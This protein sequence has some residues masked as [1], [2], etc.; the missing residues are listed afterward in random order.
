[1]AFKLA[2]VL[3]LV[4]AITISPVHPW[5]SCGEVEFCPRIRYAQAQDNFN[6]DL[7]NLQVNDNSIEAQLVNTNSQKRFSFTLTAL[8]DETYRV[9]I[10]D[11]DNKRHKVEDA[12]DGEPQ[13]VSISTQQTSNGITVSAGNSKA[14]VESSPFRIKFYRGNDVIAIINN[15]GRFAFEEREPEVAIGLDVYFPGAKKAYGLPAHSD[16]LALRNT[17]QNSYDPYR[18]YNIDHAGFDAFITQAIYGAIPVLYAHSASQSTGFFWLNSAQT[19]VDID[20]QDSGLQTF[21]FSES[22][23]MD[24]F[25]LT[26]PSLKDAVHQYAT[27]TGKLVANTFSNTRKQIFI[28]IVQI[29]WPIL[30]IC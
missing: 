15:Q 19:F 25:V 22:G 30:L 12:L 24:F 9:F 20:S 13:Q 11:P 7:S 2:A 27:L 21:W 29:S 6:L 10:D 3:A 8:A 23:V 17:G 18:F 1:M 16:H 5:F 26:G 14:E 28:E 4:L